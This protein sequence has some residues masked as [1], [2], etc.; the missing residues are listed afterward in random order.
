[1][2]TAVWGNPATEELL[3][4]AVDLLAAGDRRGLTLL[5]E[6][7][8]AECGPAFAASV[9]AA[10][11]SGT[12]PATF[13]FLPAP[14]PLSA[15]AIPA[16]AA[17]AAEERTGQAPR[18]PEPQAAVAPPLSG[19]HRPAGPVRHRTHPA[20]EPPQLPPSGYA[21]V[22]E[23]AAHFGVSVKAVYR[24]MA[25]GRIRAERR[26]GGSYRIPVDQFRT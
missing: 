5:R 3:G 26:P 2:A 22:A 14:S 4:L 20:G 7:L 11:A 21:T 13:A 16:P 23:V 6:V 12:P 15:A 9:V 8:A 10:L 24:W 1:V 18:S 17:T 19:P 25:S